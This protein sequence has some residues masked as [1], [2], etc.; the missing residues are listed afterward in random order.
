VHRGPTCAFLRKVRHHVV[1]PNS[2]A[3]FDRAE[4]GHEKNER[5]KR[6]LQESRSLSISPQPAAESGEHRRYGVT[7]NVAERVSVMELAIPGRILV[8]NVEK[9]LVV[10][11][12]TIVTR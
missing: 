11:T 9:V 3:E 2:A 1:L 10:V 7:R 12:V 4:Q 5:G 6:E 8:K